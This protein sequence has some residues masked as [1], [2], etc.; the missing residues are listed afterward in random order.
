MFSALKN[1]FAVMDPVQRKVLIGVV[2]VIIAGI[3]VI[4]FAAGGRIGTPSFLKSEKQLQVEADMKRM[5]PRNA[6]DVA[7]PRAREWDIKAELSFLKAVTSETGRA[8]SWQL[9]FVSPQKKGRGFQIEVKER[10]VTSA[11]EISYSG[12]A[13]DF[14]LDIISQEEAIRRVRQISGY[15]NEPV[16]GIEAVYGPAEKAWYWAVRTPKGVVTVEAKRT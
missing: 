4:F 10:I 15:E 14:P 7:L 5:T 3:V 16:L 11:A 13:A 6:F 8:D 12:F 1:Q 9:I 2:A